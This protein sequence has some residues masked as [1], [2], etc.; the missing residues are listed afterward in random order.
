MD[1]SFGAAGR[2]GG[3][4]GV[5]CPKQ[6]TALRQS[7][8]CHIVCV[9]DIDSGAGG[10]ATLQPTDSAEVQLGGDTYDYPCT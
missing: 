8:E 9:A 10:S 2:S 6:E 3:G 1:D 5:V 7:V 4:H